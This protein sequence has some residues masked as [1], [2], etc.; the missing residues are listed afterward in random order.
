MLAYVWLNLAKTAGHD[1]AAAA[2]AVVAPRLSTR[3][4]ARANAI[5]AP[6]PPS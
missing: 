6:V 4:R 3:D 5:L 1:G 2:L